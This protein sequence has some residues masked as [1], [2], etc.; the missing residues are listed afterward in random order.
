M[1]LCERCAKGFS[2][3]FAPID[4]TFSDMLASVFS[5][6]SANGGVQKCSGCG[7]MFSELAA[8]GKVGCANCYT[9]FR[10][11]LLPTMQKIH[12]KTKHIGKIS[13]KASA[14]YK[15]MQHLDDLKTQLK[16]AVESEDYETAAKLRD[17]IKEMSS[18]G[19]DNE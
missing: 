9:S 8:A 10:K 1:S 2:D 6:L 19:D 13:K 12:G 7:A 15:K 17:E 16:T 14:A 4:F 3:F 11:E 5:G 18:G